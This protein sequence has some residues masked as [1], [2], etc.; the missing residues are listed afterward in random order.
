MKTNKNLYLDQL[1]NWVRAE[2]SP[3]EALKY[4]TDRYMCN[5]E[6]F[7]KPMLCSIVNIVS[8]FNPDKEILTA[9]DFNE[10]V[11][12]KLD[13]WLMDMSV[14]KYPQ[15]CREIEDD[16][17]DEPTFIYTKKGQDMIERAIGRFSKI[18]E[19][20]FDEF[21]IEIKTRMYNEY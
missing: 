12:W 15:F 13:E 19:R 20:Y 21:C 1:N 10:Y 16:D 7:K 5:P 3:H 9:E 6:W 18:A 17:P 8:P 2:T 14:Y 4:F 11:E